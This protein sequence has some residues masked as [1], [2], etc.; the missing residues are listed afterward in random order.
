MEDTVRL[1]IA[2]PST[3]DPRQNLL[4]LLQV[5]VLLFI[6]VL[7]GALAT[8]CRLPA[9]VG[10]LLTGILIG[11]SVLGGLAPSVTSWLLPPNA[12]Q[13][14]LLDAVAQ[15]GVALLVGM[16]GMQV[17][18]RMARHSTKTI[19][20]SSVSSLVVPF[21]GGVAVGYLVPASLVGTA[22]D[23]LTFALFLGVA[24][25]VSAIPVI[26][27]T[28]ADMDLLYR[29]LGQLIL[30]AGM[31]DDVVAW[32]GLSV[33]SAMAT[34]GLAASAVGRSVLLLVGFVL[35]AVVLGRPLARF[36]VRLAGRA[37]EPGPTV[38]VAVVLILLTAAL[39]QSLGLEAMFGAFAAGML[40]T[41]AGADPVQ[42]APLRTVVMSVLAPLFLATAGLRV[43]L[44]L[45][46]RPELAAAALLVLAVAVG[47][48]FLGA[49]LGARLV[50][51]GHWAGIAL[52]AGLNARGVVQIVVATVGLRLGVFGTGAYTIIILI[53]MVTSL[54]A[55]PVLR[56][57]MARIPGNVRESRRRRDQESWTSPAHR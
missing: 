13:A 27:K 56:L 24:L 55:A 14:H 45:L 17:D 22:T 43:D 31:V 8:R 20:V 21:A 54:M 16:T 32:F 28:L 36:L 51:L 9:V 23:R 6:A 12:A 30:T 7:L 46:S 37:R 52:G 2:F 5:A 57:S 49:Y 11:P 15:L 25:A 1:A 34:V 3:L 26:A 33:V 53:A 50:R 39:T 19:V 10:E 29:D 35:G 40:L 44:R 41:S 38:A 42:L 4:F 18:L 47:G 48:K